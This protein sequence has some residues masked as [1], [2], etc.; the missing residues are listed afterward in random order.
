MSPRFALLILLVAGIF[1]THAASRIE[2]VEP[3]SWWIG[4]HEPTVQL[5]VHGQRIGELEAAIEYPGVK[6]ESVERVPNPN[7][8]FLN[9][10]IAPD[11]RP[12]RMQIEL[13]RNG[14]SVARWPYE[15]QAREAGSA[16]RAGFGPGDVVYL[17]TPDRFANGDPANDTVPGFGD[18]PDRTQPLGR[19]GGDLAGVIKHLDYVAGLGFTQLW[20]NPVVENAQ[21]DASYHGYAITD[22]Y[23]VDPRFGSN[24]LYRQLSHDARKRG[25]GLI[26]DV[27]L[28]HCGSNH[29]W[30][31]DLPAPDWINN[32]GRFVATT[33]AREVLQDPHG[34]AADYAAF[35]D[36]WFVATMPDL[37]QRNPLLATY[38]IQNSLWWIEYAGL[39]GLRVDTYPYSDR[40]FLTAW[41]KRV[42]EEYPNL[43]V[44]GEEWT[45]NP[46]SV[47]YWMRGNEP[48]DGYRSYLPGL[49][50]F[51]L[52]DALKL[53][54]VE[55][56]GWG[57]GL[58]RIYRTIA[59]DVV[60]A[61]PSQ[62]MVFAD[63]H[64]MSRI[65]TSLGGRADLARMALTL[66][67]TTRGTPQVFYGTE[68]LMGNPGTEDHGVI[69]GDFPGG[70]PGDASNAFTGMGLAPA[71][72]AM[73][74][75]LRT[76]LQWRRTSSAMREGTLTH[77]YPVDG[78]YVYFRRAPTQTVMVVLNVNDTAR[79]V[80][81]GRYAEAIGGATRAI[82]VVSR[83]EQPL[84]P[85]ISVPP[86]SATVLEL[87]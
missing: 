8:L 49:F 72:L 54:L 42:T 52:Q 73:Q 13:R 20:L 63:N 29:W 67:L 70:F 14:R 23:R 30:M 21:P 4:M 34:A 80:E 44:V 6:L 11:T 71:A 50:D 64:D 28:N 35:A 32:G 77:F 81:P 9:L 27:V 74:D 7:Y 2:R 12:G 41:S 65:F 53:G 5:L 46:I 60:Y 22:F 57:S 17:I 56:E 79:T 37:N 39:S 66:V 45:S 16:T 24:E 19:H 55:P 68:V 87:H 83:Q 40:A 58:R 69:R 62:L 61:D 51:P 82:D 31:R 47:A 1:E 18:A 25:M 43:G 76:L 26:M 59:S 85:G 36:G 15:L 48:R 10:R 33:H 78:L 38:L 3:L 84:T 75:Y 86:R